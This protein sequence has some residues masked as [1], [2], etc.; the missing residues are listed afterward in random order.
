MTGP[1]DRVTALG[2][3]ERGDALLEQG[4][5]DAA[6]AHYARVVGHPDPDITA[7][8]WYRLGEARWRRSD[9]DGA[10]AAWEAAAR[11][12]ETDTA[13]EAWRRL[14]AARVERARVKYRWAP[15]LSPLSL[16]SQPRRALI[17]AR[18]AG[19]ARRSAS[20]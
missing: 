17:W 7:A 13:W 9:E 1:L 4:E 2:L 10:M 6:A 3:L 11:V 15:L 16:V 8:A 12:G 19:G 14:A 18:S 5:V 20:R